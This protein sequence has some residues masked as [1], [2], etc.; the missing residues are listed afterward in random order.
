MMLDW[1]AKIANGHQS[2]KVDE[3][4]NQLAMSPWLMEWIVDKCEKEIQRIS[5]AAEKLNKDTE[6]G[7]LQDELVYCAH[8][9]ISLHDYLVYKQVTIFSASLL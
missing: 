4:T 3:I 9:L 1:N 7:F 2:S 6:Y 5:A 8:E